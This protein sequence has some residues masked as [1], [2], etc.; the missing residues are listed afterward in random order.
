MR[1]LHGNQA[2]LLAGLFAYNLVRELQMRTTQPLRHTTAKRVS[3]WV[4]EKVD[5]LR[6]TLLQ[7]A[8]RFTRP[9]GRLTLT[10][11]ANQWIQ[12]KLTGMLGSDPTRGMRAEF[13]ATLGF[14]LHF[15]CIATFVLVKLFFTK[16]LYQ[17]RELLSIET[18][19]RCGLGRTDL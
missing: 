14:T 12:R 9:K 1:S 6:K 11:S 16:N 8:G 3:L 4:F 15:Y 5:T 10:I 7:R 2:Y 18:M 17:Q 13:Y 19:Q